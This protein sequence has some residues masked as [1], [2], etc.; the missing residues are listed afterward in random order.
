MGQSLQSVLAKSVLMR[1]LRWMRVEDH[2]VHAHSPTRCPPRLT[3]GLRTERPVCAPVA[4]PY[5]KPASGTLA[6]CSDTLLC[7]LVAGNALPVHM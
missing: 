3:R 6:A 4:P 2:P 7:T 5:A 1:H